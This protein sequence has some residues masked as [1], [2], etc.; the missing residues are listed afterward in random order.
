MDILKNLPGMDD[1]QMN[2][3][4]EIVQ[5]EFPYMSGR[6][7]VDAH[8]PIER[9]NFL[10]SSYSGSGKYVDGRYI[11]P[12][13]REDF[14]SFNLRKKKVRV[15]N[16]FKTIIDS[17]IAPIFENEAVRDIEITDS[18]YVSA[19]EQFINDCDRK[20]TSYSDFMKMAA[21]AARKFDSAFVIVENASNIG[22][23]TFYDLQN[24]DNLPYL[25]LLT[26][27][28]VNEITLDN[29]GNVTSISWFYV[30]ENTT[31]NAGAIARRNAPSI[32]ISWNLNTWRKTINGETIEQGDNNLGYIPVIPIYPEGNDNPSITPFPYGMAYSLAT[33]QHRRYNLMS[34]MDEIVDGQAFSILVVPGQST[35]NLDVGVGNA[36]IGSWENGNMPE[37]ISPDASN[38]EFIRKEIDSLTI[39]MYRTANMTHLTTYAQSAESKRLD[40]E[41]TYKALTD[42]QSTIKNVDMNIM[43]IFGEYM[44]IDYGYTVSYSNS[45]GV[46]TLYD[47]VDIFTKL[48]PYAQNLPPVLMK[49]IANKIAQNLFSNSTNIDET[50][51][52]IDAYYDNNIS[53]QLIV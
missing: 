50:I 16:D 37:Y 9:W 49:A 51:R 3:K 20:G 34:I 13:R 24:R 27:D 38:M 42:F 18:A 10:D 17:W 52:E 8:S 23:M 21:R 43:R 2:P 22:A 31:E 25:I 53:S 32:S 40:S 41:R 4:A 45:F 46:D 33:L 35:Q 29:S 48:S 5:T 7:W 39:D 30:E 1:V 44:G 12:H 36:L 47:T 28:K 6:G 14:D 19:Y 26:P 11:I 15:V